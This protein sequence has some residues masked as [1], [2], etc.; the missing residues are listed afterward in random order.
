MPPADVGRDEGSW[1]TY[2][3]P[4]QRY[5]CGSK[6]GVSLVL[7]VLLPT[8]TPSYLTEARFQ[9]HQHAS[10]PRQGR[11]VVR[12]VTMMK[13]GAK[14]R[15]TKVCKCDAQNDKNDAYQERRYKRLLLHCI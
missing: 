3:Q 6:T 8:V 5:G 13:K 10:R 4:M 2:G 11:G 15:R 12:R 1:M 9:H 14:P 7:L